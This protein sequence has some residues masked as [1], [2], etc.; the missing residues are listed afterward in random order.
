M[1]EGRI[2]GQSVPF[3]LVKL[4]QSLL[5][6][7]GCLLDG[8]AACGRPSL[9]VGDIPITCGQFGGKELS[10]TVGS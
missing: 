5:P 6:V 10:R 1:A 8:V 7:F 2:P 4:R 9:G 3:Q